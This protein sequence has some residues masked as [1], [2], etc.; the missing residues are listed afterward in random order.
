MGLAAPAPTQRFRIA[1]MALTAKVESAVMKSEA[2]LRQQINLRKVALQMF[3]FRIL[4]WR[5]LS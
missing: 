4:N 2:S 5:E 3:E 1:D